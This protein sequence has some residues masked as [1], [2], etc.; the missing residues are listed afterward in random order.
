MIEAKKR[1]PNVVPI[2][3]SG[4]Y[5]TH[6]SG[7]Y[8]NL[9]SQIVERDVRASS[10]PGGFEAAIEVWAYVQSLPES[11][12]VIASLGRRDLGTD[13]GMPRLVGHARPGGRRL[14]V[15][16]GIQS[17]AIWDH[18]LKFHID[19]PHDFQIGDLVGWGISHP[20]TTLDKWKAIHLINE[21]DIVTGVM[22]TYF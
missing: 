2:L 14:P 9:F 4:C 18:H 10:V 19:E 12:T 16:E 6:D 8:K 15:P 7:I 20:C 22:A 17:V 21:F 5:I 13:S 11:G 1:W 3:R